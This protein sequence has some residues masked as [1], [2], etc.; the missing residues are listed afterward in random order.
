MASELLPETKVCSMCKQRKPK[1]AFHVRYA[2]KEE[3]T[4]GLANRCIDCYTK[5]RAINK[6]NV[7][8]QYRYN[9]TE[10][11]YELM[12]KSQN[13][14]C[15][16]C[17]KPGTKK[18]KGIVDRLSVDHDHATMKIRGLLCYRCNTMLG[19]VENLP[20]GLQSI[21]NYLEEGK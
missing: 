12:L 11:Q 20:E 21:I 5:I 14:V 16:L 3:N 13:E 4:S 8:L 6:R 9:V 15:A 1:G 10:A 17:G 19:V 7:T 18:Q 2:K